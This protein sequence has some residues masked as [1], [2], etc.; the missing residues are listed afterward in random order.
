MAVDPEHYKYSNE[1]GRAGY[2][3]HDDF[4]LKN[5]FVLHVLY[6]NIWVF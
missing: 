3:I 2:D 1:A 5:P 6:K 4:K